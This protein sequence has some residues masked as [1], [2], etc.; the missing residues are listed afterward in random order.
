MT[1]VMRSLINSKIKTKHIP[2][3]LKIKRYF[4]FHTNII[5]RHTIQYNYSRRL[6]WFLIN[7]N[8]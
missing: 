6:T 7:E 1:D 5:L 4:F 8:R 2:D 3:S